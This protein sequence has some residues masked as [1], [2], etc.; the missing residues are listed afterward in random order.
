MSLWKA[1][2]DVNV[3]CFDEVRNDMVRNGVLTVV[4]LVPG[5]RLVSVSGDGSSV[6]VFR[7]IHR[8]INEMDVADRMLTVTGIQ[9]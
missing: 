9:C 4:M 3:L 7:A 5:V 1:G 8:V 6:D 2:L